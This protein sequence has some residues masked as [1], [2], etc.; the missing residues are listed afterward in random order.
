MQ[1]L[2][3]CVLSNR[4]APSI[5]SRAP[6]FPR[7]FGG[8]S[9]VQVSCLFCN[10]PICKHSGCPTRTAQTKQ[11]HPNTCATKVDQVTYLRQPPRRGAGERQLLRLPSP[12]GRSGVAAGLRPPAVREIP[13]GRHRGRRA[14]G[15]GL[16]ERRCTWRGFGFS[17]CF[18]LAGERIPFAVR[19]ACFE[20]RLA[21]LLCLPGTACRLASFYFSK[22]WS[23]RKP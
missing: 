15:A 20:C 8:I 10:L 16:L 18:T 6:Q 5:P 12:P 19:L 11:T 7:V 13:A 17:S 9:R 1:L 14:A 2:E 21:A 22:E 23:R 3:E 4:S